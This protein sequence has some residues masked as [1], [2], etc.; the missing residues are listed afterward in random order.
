VKG[1][2]LADRIGEVRAPE[3]VLAER[4]RKGLEEKEKR[5]KLGKKVRKL[6]VQFRR[7]K[8]KKKKKRGREEESE[9][10]REKRRTGREGSFERCG[11]GIQVPCPGWAS[12]SV[13]AN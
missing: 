3:D 12:R 4:N 7:K 9:R 2:G 6:D 8:K 10:E 13:R 1:F 11:R 5:K